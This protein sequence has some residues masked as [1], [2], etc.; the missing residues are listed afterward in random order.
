MKTP[1]DRQ[2]GPGVASLLA[3]ESQAN[4]V[5]ERCRSGGA[6]SGTVGQAASSGPRTLRAAAWPSGIGTASPIHFASS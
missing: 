3:F 6:D 2:L 1:P 5:V 4:R